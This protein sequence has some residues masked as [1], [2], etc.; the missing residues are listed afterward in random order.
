LGNHF[1]HIVIAVDGYLMGV[2]SDRD[3]TANWEESAID[4]KIGEIMITTLTVAP[5]TLYPRRPR[6]YCHGEIVSHLQAQLVGLLTSR[7]YSVVQGVASSTRNRIVNMPSQRCGT[8][9]KSLSPK[10]LKNCD[11]ITRCSLGSSILSVIYG[12][13]KGR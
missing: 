7:Y 9:N 12:A 4:K 2:L 5:E 1:H 10:S 6:K 13:S 3:V 11:S 8:P